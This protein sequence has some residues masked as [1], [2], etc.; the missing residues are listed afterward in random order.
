[1]A[2]AMAEVS[3]RDETVS[4]VAARRWPAVLV[5]RMATNS[6]PTRGS[7]SSVARDGGAG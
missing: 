7:S 3:M 5:G 2:L 1:M 6:A 4:T